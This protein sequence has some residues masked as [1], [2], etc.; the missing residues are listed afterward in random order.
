M[1]PGIRLPLPFFA[2][3][4]LRIRFAVEMHRSHT[5]VGRR[6]R[7]AANVLEG[8]Y[9]GPL[10]AVDWKQPSGLPYEH[11]A[12]RWA[13]TIAEGADTRKLKDLRVRESGKHREAHGP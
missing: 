5:G 8:K 6:G 11:P 4:A 12:C 7:L 10:G 9:G 13:R 3:P 2:T 1:A